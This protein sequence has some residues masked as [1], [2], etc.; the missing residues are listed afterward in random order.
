MNSLKIFSLYLRSTDGPNARSIRGR[1]C[2]GRGLDQDLLGFRCTRDALAQ[3]SLRYCV[4]APHTVVWCVT[5]QRLGVCEAML[6]CGA[7]RGARSL[8]VYMIRL[9]AGSGCSRL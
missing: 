9:R 5:W 3:P 6:Q 7:P 4:V 2:R 8:R 1:G